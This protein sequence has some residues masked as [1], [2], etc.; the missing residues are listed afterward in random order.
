MINIPF[1]FSTN[2][3]GKGALIKK[4]ELIILVIDLCM[5]PIW[6]DQFLFHLTS[7][8]SSIDND[9]KNFNVYLLKL[10][11]YILNLH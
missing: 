7:L 5:S 9:P 4:D 11:E 3:F 2:I 8:S 6:F 1:Q 10:S